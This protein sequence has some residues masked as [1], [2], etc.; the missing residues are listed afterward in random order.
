MGD[1]SGE[2]RRWWGRFRALDG[3]DPGWK[4]GSATGEKSE[5][6]GLTRP[7]AGSCSCWYRAIVGLKKSSSMNRELRR[8][9]MC[10]TE[11][12]ALRR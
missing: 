8:V 2:Y 6:G 9:S 5:A 11:K 3:N 10:S 7:L 4:E 1:R 12:S